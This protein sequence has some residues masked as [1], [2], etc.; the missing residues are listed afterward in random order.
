M[1]AYCEVMAPAGKAASRLCL[2][3]KSSLNEFPIGS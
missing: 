2:R 3:V 1:A